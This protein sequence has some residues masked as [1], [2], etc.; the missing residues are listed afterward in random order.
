[1]LYRYFNLV[2]EIDTYSRSNEERLPH[3][4]NIQ[5]YFFVR[6]WERKNRHFRPLS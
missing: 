1:M 6:L 2:P 3:W 5:G 4:K